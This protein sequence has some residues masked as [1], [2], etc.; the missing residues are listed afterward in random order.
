MNDLIRE[1][2]A[3]DYPDFFAYL[4][5]QLR[6]NGKNG[7]PLFQPLSRDIETFPPEKEASFVAGLAKSIGQPGW[8]RAWVI[9]GESGNI[10]GHM[11]L[12]GHPDAS[13]THRALLGMGVGIA[14][15]RRGLASQ[16]LDFA[17]EW[18][19]E[20]DMLEWIDIEVLAA[21]TPAVSLYRKH[22]F[23]QLGEIPDFY[24]IDGHHESVI[25]M[26]WHSSDR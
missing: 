6:D 12:R 4:N 8:R 25:R 5:A 19:S 13:I 18:V 7:H 16:L 23:R 15:R 11:D 14:F 10:M 22:G 3:R 26:A 17:C 24:R 2:A 9:C 1:L 21:N 20:H